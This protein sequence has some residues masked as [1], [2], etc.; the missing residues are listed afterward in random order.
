MNAQ[1]LTFNR[2]Y[3]LQLKGFTSINPPRSHIT[4]TS[5]KKA[6]IKN[7]HL[8]APGESPNTDG[9]DIS[10]SRD[11]QVLNSFIGTGD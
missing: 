4:L 5:C 9:I 3:R 8:I 1:A 7:L 6:I 11:I 2:C 10:G